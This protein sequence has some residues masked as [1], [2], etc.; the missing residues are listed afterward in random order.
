M[1]IEPTPE[2]IKAAAAVQMTPDEFLHKAIACALWNVDGTPG[3][4][5]TGCGDTEMIGMNAPHGSLV[6]HMENM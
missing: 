4:R 1:D 2:A 3:P 5:P 6:V